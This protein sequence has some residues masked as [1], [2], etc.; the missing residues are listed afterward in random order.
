MLIRVLTVAPVMALIA[1]CIIF[2]CKPSAFG[3]AQNFVMSVIFLTVMPL[4][5]YPMQPLIPKFKESGRA[6]QRK[7]AII[8]AVVGYILGIVYALVRN[9]PAE[10]MLI[11]LTYLISGILIAVFN[12]LLKIKASGHACGVAGPIAYLYYFVGKYALLGL[13][14]MTAVI[15]SSIKMK[16]HTLSQLVVGSLISVAATFIALL[17]TGL[18]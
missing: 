16:R 17:C 3:S 7:L 9:V 10:L 1:L 11:Y 18:M 13:T 6:G 8:M 14:V 4:L 5:A 12:K 15:I 2:I